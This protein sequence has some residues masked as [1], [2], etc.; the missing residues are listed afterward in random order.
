MSLKRAKVEFFMLIEPKGLQMQRI[1]YG[2]QGH[3]SIL[4]NFCGRQYD[5]SKRS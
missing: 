4:L 1:V 2:M 5:G 3:K